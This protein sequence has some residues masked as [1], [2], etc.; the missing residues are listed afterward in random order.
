MGCIDYAMHLYND[1]KNQNKGCLAVMEDNYKNC[2]KCGFS[3]DE[4][5]ALTIAESFDFGP[6]AS[7]KKL[8]ENKE[9]NIEF[10]CQVYE[11]NEKVK[12]KN[13]RKTN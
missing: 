4:I 12:E 2:C 7:H 9:L 8:Y 10:L 5:K 1:S 13:E 11:E 3:Q 6:E